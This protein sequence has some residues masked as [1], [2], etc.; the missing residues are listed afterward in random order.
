[1]K[2][3]RCHIF[4]RHFG[5]LPVGRIGDEFSSAERSFRHFFLLVNALL[6]P[7]LFGTLTERFPGLL[8]IPS[9]GLSWFCTLSETFYCTE[10]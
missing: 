10:A 5:Q 4:I 3:K 7:P 1:M 6:T 9:G 8:L 2:D